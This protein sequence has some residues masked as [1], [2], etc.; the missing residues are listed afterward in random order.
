M[1]A[2]G[3]MQGFIMS[4]VPFILMGVFF[5]L[6]PNYIMPLFTHFL[7]WIALGI[8]FILQILGGYMIKK[9]ITVDV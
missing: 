2:Q 3:V 9:I 6:D 4:S 7:G 8:M 1:T 5:L